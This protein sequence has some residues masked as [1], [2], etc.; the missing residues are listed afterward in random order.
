MT[1]LESLKTRLVSDHIHVKLK[2]IKA[3]LS[4]PGD[5]LTDSVN[6]KMNGY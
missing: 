2:I 6:T 3:G 1:E 4:Y 5:F